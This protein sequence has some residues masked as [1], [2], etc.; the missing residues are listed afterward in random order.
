MSDEY[1]GEFEWRNVQRWDI[2][3]KEIVTHSAACYWI[4]WPQ[5][6]DLKIIDVNKTV[7]TNS[8]DICLQIEYS[9]INKLINF[10]R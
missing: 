9:V 8:S 6:Y 4:S 2:L 3:K 1:R 7:S 10:V 5:I